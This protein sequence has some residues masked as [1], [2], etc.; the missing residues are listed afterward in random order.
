MPEGNRDKLLGSLLWA[1][2]AACG[3][4]TALFFTVIGRIQVSF[5]NGAPVFAVDSRG[6]IALTKD[7]ALQAVWIL[8]VL[9]SLAVFW[10]IYRRPVP[11]SRAWRLSGALAVGLAIAGGLAEP[12]WA[13]VLLGDAAVLA[14]TV[15]WATRR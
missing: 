15:W 1:A 10:V 2:V 13:V 7:M 5:V 9:F 12:W 4:Y 14:A 6:P 8:T 11:T 3:Q